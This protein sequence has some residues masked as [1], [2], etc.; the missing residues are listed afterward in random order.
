MFHV[1]SA[2]MRVRSR[3]LVGGEDAVE[4]AHPTAV[5]DE[6]VVATAAAEE[7]E[8]ALQVLVGDRGS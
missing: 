2:E 3:E 4:P 6:R 7:E 5:H 1:P 8:P